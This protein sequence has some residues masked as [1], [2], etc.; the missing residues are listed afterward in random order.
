MKKSI[1]AAALAAAVI[2]TASSLIGCS[3]Y[4]NPEKYITI[5]GKGEVVVKNSDIDEDYNEN[6]EEI[7][8]DNRETYYKP[9][10]DKDEA[11]KDGD[12]V[13]I[14][15]TGTPEDPTLNLAQTTID[16]MKYDSSS[17]EED[18]D[19]KGYGLVIGSGSFIKAYTD[20]SDEKN[21]TD[22]FEDQIIGHK[23]SEGKFDITVTFPSD[24]SNSE[25]QKVRAV[26]TVEIVSVERAYVA[27]E[28]GYTDDDM[29]VTVGYEFT[30]PTE[31]EDDAD[32]DEDK[33]T[34]TED[35]VDTTDAED[36]VET[37]T[38]TKKFS[39]I[40]KSGTFSYTLDDEE[41][42]KDKKFL[43]FLKVSDYVEQIAGKAL[44]EE[45][46]VTITVPED[47]GDSYKDYVGKE[48]EMKL[49]ATKI[50]RLPKW[51]DKFIND[52][53][54]GQYE[55][56]DAYKEYAWNALAQNAAF[57]AISDKVEVKEYPQSEL[58]S[59]YK[60]YVYQLVYSKLSNKD[61]GDFTQK[62]LNEKISE[63]DYE[64]IYNSAAV[65]AKDSVRQRLIIEYLCNY[66]DITLSSKE[67]DEKLSS[68]LSSN[69]YTYYQYGIYTTDSLESYYGKDYFELQF[70]TEKMLE[71][72]TEYVTFED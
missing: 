38:E 68:E 18:S 45:I 31:D 11:V 66:F 27:H 23:V 71:K 8:E 61:P 49:T 16:G 28:D 36:E 30:E 33:T 12:K 24:Y 47:A 32:K 35:D 26:F 72:I 51:D 39:D 4:K 17:D 19:E 50:E 29:Q 70:K 67:Y 1:R 41:S 57:E 6:I 3:A 55:T 62:E 56:I 60:N 9:L 54:S 43:D 44:N 53:T 5:P 64:E 15:Y 21:N 2:L 34:E 59:T 37:P 7:R 10:T 13:Y 40:F 22:G 20:S 14:Y 63:S 46:T 52:Y 25:L 69:F 65:S 58:K 48:I 42:Y